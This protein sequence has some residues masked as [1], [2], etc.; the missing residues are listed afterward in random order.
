MIS[1]NSLNSPIS[2]KRIVEGYIS[3]VNKADFNEISRYL[4]DSV[5]TEELEFLLSDNLEDFYTMF[6]WDSVFNPRYEIID[7]QELEKGMQL[8][9]SKE[10]KRI[11]FLNDTALITRSM[12]EF[13]NGRITR[14]QTYEYLNLDFSK[15]ESRRD[16][17][18]AWIGIHHPNLNG[19]DITQT[20]DGGQNYLKAIELYRN[21]N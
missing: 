19:F 3:A 11:L 12:V 4:N 6:Q 7:I 10:C 1:C 21:R 9:L 20:I 8:T 13:S 16:T 2:H 17:L 5:R 18:I 14:I 15:W